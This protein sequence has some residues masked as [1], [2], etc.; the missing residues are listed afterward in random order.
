[1]GRLLVQQSPIKNKW[2][3]IRLSQYRV[4]SKS[5]FFSKCRLGVTKVSVSESVRVCTG[6]VFCLIRKL[7]SEASRGVMDANI[8]TKGRA[9]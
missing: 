4:H 9:V 3:R 2:D 7:N 6:D 5:F 1:M 8:N